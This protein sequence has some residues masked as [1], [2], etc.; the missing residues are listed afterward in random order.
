MKLTTLIKSHWDEAA[1]YLVTVA[2]ALVSRY[3]T[4]LDSGQPFV[5][6]LGPV[7]LAAFTSIFIAFLAERGG[8]PVAPDVKQ[9]GKKR[10]RGWRI[11]NAALYGYAGQ[12]IIPGLVKG[13][14]AVYGA[15]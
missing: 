15:S 4:Q 10:N 8:G 3:Q 2:G 11:A 7:I 14:A 1:V 13:L 5:I 12:Y 9:A 6:T